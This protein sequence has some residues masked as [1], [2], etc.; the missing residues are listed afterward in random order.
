MPAVRHTVPAHAAATDAGPSRTHRDNGPGPPRTRPR[1]CRRSGTRCRRTPR[2]PTPAH[3]GRIERSV[4]AHRGPGRGDAGGPA[5]GA[6]AR[7]GDRRRPIED[8]SGIC[9]GPPGARS[10]VSTAARHTVP[11]RAAAIVAVPSRAYRD[12]VP[13]RRGPVRVERCTAPGPPKCGPGPVAEA[14]RVVE[15]VAV[16]LAPPLPTQ[17]RKAGSCGGRSWSA[18]D[19]ISS[20][21]KDTRLGA[22]I[23]AS[24]QT[25]A[26]G[27]LPQP[28]TQS[29]LAQASFFN[30]RQAGVRT[31]SVA[32]GGGDPAPS[33]RRSHWAGVGLRRASTVPLRRAHRWKYHGELLALPHSARPRTARRT[34]VLPEG[35]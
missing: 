5:H 4:P 29:G 16:V 1:R 12:S 13:A 17:P 9:P 6:G 27:E 28:M 18:A 32:P 35:T 14:E 25:R 30:V 23:R 22:Q 19:A 26:E 8:A 7:R 24:N 11:A 21:P 2:R 15:G 33:C 10:A 34:P 31:V 20:S 3:R